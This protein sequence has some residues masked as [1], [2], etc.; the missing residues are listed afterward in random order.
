MTATLHPLKIDVAQFGTA[1]QL[2]P[3]IQANCQRGL[4]ELT[5]SILAH[6]GSLVLVASGPSMPSQLEAIRAE[7]AKGRTICAI[8]AAHDW[9]CEHDVEPD[10]FLTV[11]P[12]DL[13]HNLRRK[14]ARTRYLLASRVAPEVFAHL[15]ECH[16]WLWHSFGH[17]AEVDAI[18]PYAKM[19]VGGGSTSGLR[20]IAVGHLFF[21]FRNF[22][23][24]GY[25]SCNTPDGKFK[26]FD[27]SQSGI[28]TDVICGDRTF[29]C[30]MAMAAQANEFQTVT[31][32][33]LP[34]IHI[35]AFGD[36]LIAAILAE[37]T[38]LGKPV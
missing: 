21:G 5:P 22:R 6:D 30:N 37:R 28:T 15:A 8:N 33:L 11:D 32:G 31:Y 23:L 10:L 4:P 3:T 38:R 35:E 16:V 36:G 29:I 34:D 13:R 25:D 27:G 1:T 17:K 2:V 24:Y 7:R 26:R 19:A 14:N 9:L 12:R 20:A 18:H